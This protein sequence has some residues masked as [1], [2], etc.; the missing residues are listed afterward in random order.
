MERSLHADLFVPIKAFEEKIKQI[1]SQSVL[2]LKQG[3]IVKFE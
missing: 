3:P 1:M 2:E